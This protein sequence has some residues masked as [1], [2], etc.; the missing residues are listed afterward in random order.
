MQIKAT[1]TENPSI[2]NISVTISDVVET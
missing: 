1:I 2:V